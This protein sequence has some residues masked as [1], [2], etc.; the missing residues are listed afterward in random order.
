MVEPEL[1]QSHNQNGAMK[2]TVNGGMGIGVFSNLLFWIN[3]DPQ[4]QFEGDARVESHEALDN[5][6]RSPRIEDEA[7][8]VGGA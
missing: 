3:Q 1:E 5:Q 8:V 7:R 6:S 4:S 2:Q